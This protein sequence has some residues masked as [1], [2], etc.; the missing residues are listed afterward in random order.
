MPRPLTSLGVLVVLLPVACGS[1][2]AVPR[3]DGGVS[4][5]TVTIDVGGSDSTTTISDS[6]AP[7]M[8]QNVDVTIIYPLPA[9]AELDALL[10]PGDV[11][12]GG[13][14]LAADVFDQSHVP[15]LDA[16]APLPDDSERLAALRVVAIRFDPCPGNVVPPPSGAT[17]TPELRLVFQSLEVD[18]AETSARDG[19]IHTF[20]AMS[21][22]DFD[23]VVRALRDIRAEQAGDPPV[24]LDVHPLLRAQGPDGA[25]AR[26]I[27]P[28]VLAHAGISN[29][30]RV[31]HFRR[32]IM[33]TFPSWQF[34]LRERVA[35][36]WQDRMIPTTTVTQ[37]G[38]VTIVGGTWDASINPDVTAPDDPRRVL[39]APSAERVPAFAATVRVLNP[40]AHTSQSID[41]AS[42]HIAPD[43][44]IFV[45]AT[46]SLR[47]EDDPQHFQSIYPLDAVPKN[48]LAATAFDNI[49]MTSY[50]GRALSLS[51]RTVNE[52]AAVLELLNGR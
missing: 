13:A 16:R 20:H 41:C 14:L 29:L 26:R 49:H 2:S 7:V 30:V 40:R 5:G 38:L 47:V 15:E 22:T 11:G 12:L 6:G 43:I 52:T 24:P 44:A 28:L 45:R 48:S 8:L 34:A 50:S 18:G 17:C 19:A 1:S 4:D 39:R 51:A 21:G 27:R 25:Y 23:A 35:G 36:A 9:A 42:C 33:S 31:T 37:Q 3:E 32:E 10:K 46:Q